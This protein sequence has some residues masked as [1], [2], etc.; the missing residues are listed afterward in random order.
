[1]ENNWPVT[2]LQWLQDFA[3]STEAAVLGQLGVLSGRASVA[4]KEIT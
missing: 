1:M 3:F 4:A 2:T